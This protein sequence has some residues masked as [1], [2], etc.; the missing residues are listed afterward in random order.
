[1]VAVKF[2]D[3]SLAFDFV[4]SAAPMEHGAYISL[5]RGQ[6]FWMSEFTSMD[7]EVPDDLETSDRYVAI[8]HKNDLNLGRELAFR[9]VAEYLPNRYGD[10]QTCFRSKGAYSQFKQLLRDEAMLDKWY[11]FEAAA[12]EKAILE[13]CEQNGIEI[14]E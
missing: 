7:E 3:I 14:I 8:P 1:V 9:F 10:V 12:V 4:S 5:E 11:S 13:W 2:D 6:I